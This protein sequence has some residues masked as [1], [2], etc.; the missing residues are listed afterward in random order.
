MDEEIKETRQITL[1]NDEVKHKI[2]LMSNMEVKNSGLPASSKSTKYEHILPKLA[3]IENDKDIEG[4]L[5]LLNT[6]GGDV[7]AG[8]AISEMIASV[9]KPTVSLRSGRKSFHWVPLAV[10]LII[11]LSYPLE[12]C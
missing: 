3:S 11:H 5:I 6:V 2:H 7:E 4:I 8:L 10:F 1:D 12:R 9:S